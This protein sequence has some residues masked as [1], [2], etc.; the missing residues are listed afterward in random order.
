VTG[1]LPEGF[2]LVFD[3]SV[4]RRGRALIGGSPLR[5]L[6]LTDAGA[7]VVE[8]LAAGEPLPADPGAQRLARRLL[9]AGLAHP[10]PPAAPFDVQ[11]VTVVVPV[12]DRPDGLR[13]L[14]AALGPVNRVVVVDDGSLEPVRATDTE[15]V[16]RPLA[17]G[18]AAARNTGLGVVRTPV[19]AFVDS[20]CRPE[21]GWLEPL[22][23]HLA[24]PLVA[25]V[26]PRITTGGA[27]TLGRYDGARSPLDLGPREGRVVARTRIGYVPAAA[28][29][30][31]T[32]ALR[33]VG[34]FDEG[35]RV[36]ED[37]DLVWRLGEAGLTVRYEPAAVVAHD[38][39]PRLDDWFSRRYWYGR[40]AAQLAERH[41]GAL[42]PLGISPASAA[43][44]L[45]AAAGRPAHGSLVAAGSA[46][47]LARRLPLPW[48][49]AVRLAGE[50]TLAAWRPL[51][52]AVVRTWW[53]AAL[54]LSFRSAVARRA[55]IAGTVAAALLDWRPGDLDPVRYAALHVLDDAAYGAGVWVGCLRH[56]TAEPL[57]GIRPRRH[58]SRQVVGQ[59]HEQLAPLPR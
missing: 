14:L 12:R 49:A 36:G 50:G 52:D 46:V 18:P 59:H 45:L 24:D 28:L 2:R 32:S 15:V 55:L 58:A 44:W 19:V 9:D 57:L 29:V 4:R 3:A 8:Q 41:P 42:A 20:D 17:D 34:G 27:S 38:E 56:R 54:V 16:R 22:L 21:P 35:L 26:A 6:R 39:R 30:A 11:D 31:R 51:A 7:A 10:R 5:L 53:P 40:S 37:V 25:A 33:A 47:L 13:R 43:A 23:L 48:S 1:T